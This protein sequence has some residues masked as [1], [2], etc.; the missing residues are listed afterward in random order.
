VSQQSTNHSFDELARALASG[1]LSRGK[2]LRLMGGLLVGSVL[3]SL[4]GVAWAD[5]D[6]DERCRST[7]TRCKERCVNLRTNERHCGSCFNRC[8]SNQTCCGGR[9]VNLQR[10][11]NHCGGCFNRCA[12]GQECVDGMCQGGVCLGTETAGECTCALICGVDASQFPCQDTLGC[13]CNLTIEEEGFCA[14]LGR[15]GECPP[16]AECSSSDG[17]AAA[18]PGWKCVI[19]TCCGYPICAPPCTP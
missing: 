1:A 17:C 12:E 5:D 19:N 14:D 8:T 13:T 16:A 18:N 7:Q 11:E 9:C 15:I 2:A 4:P 3:A 10:N 6:D